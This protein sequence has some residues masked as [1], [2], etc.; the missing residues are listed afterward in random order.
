[1]AGRTGHLCEIDI[2]ECLSVELGCQN[3]GTCADSNDD[4]VIALAE[5]IC[6]CV[7]GWHGDVCTDGP[8]G[9][10]AEIVVNQTALECSQDALHQTFTALFEP[11]AQ[12]SVLNTSNL[13]YVVAFRPHV[14]DESLT[15]VTLRI[16]SSGRVIGSVLA[17]QAL[18]LNATS[19]LV[20]VWEILEG[21]PN[22]CTNCTH[23]HCVGESDG[24]A[25]CECDDGWIGP[26]C[27]VDHDECAQ[28]PCQNSGICSDSTSTMTNSTNSTNL[29]NSNFTGSTR[30]G[31]VA[32]G[33]FHC[34]C[35]LGWGG[36]TCESDVDECASAPCQN[37]GS[38][39]ESTTSAVAVGRFACACTGG[40]E[41]VT[42]AEDVDECLADNCHSAATCA[43]SRNWQL[44]TNDSIAIGQ[45]L[46]I[47]PP[48]YMQTELCDQD[49]DECLSN[50]CQNAGVC[51]ESAVAVCAYFNNLGTPQECPAAW[52]PLLAPAADDFFCLCD[53]GWSGKHCEDEQGLYDPCHPA[54][55]ERLEGTF[56]N[57][58]ENASCTTDYP[59]VYHSYNC[60]CAYGFVGDGDEN[61]TD[62]DECASD[63][64][65]SHTQACLESYTSANISGGYFN[66][67]CED[68]YGGDLC[69]QDIDECASNPCQNTDRSSTRN[70]TCFASYT[71]SECTGAWF[72]DPDRSWADCIQSMWETVGIYR[73]VCAEGFV[74]SNCADDVDECA[75]VPCGA[76]GA[77][78]E[79]SADRYRK[80][81]VC[82]ICSALLCVA[83][84]I[85]AVC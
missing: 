85:A 22:N 35:A 24:I 74:G 43:D 9:A 12:D 31:V 58:T 67:S 47:C 79:S 5:V 68:G 61:C 80:T 50:P 72:R 63:P 15:I 19:Q 84:T 65:S 10:G 40:W 20:R 64:C 7:D 1:M 76:H 17:E 55:P 26:N 69:E 38:C 53:L 11:H 8:F 2:D 66:C 3:N 45:F 42:C 49:I 4:V 23:G 60:S 28:S 21:V 16:K 6:Q 34:D 75:S 14:L 56:H 39:S 77:C 51:F 54:Y 46:C 78:L 33:Q 48:G 41:N 18:N 32:V 62:I 83:H 73:C 82:N 81:T 30:L 57:C 52:Q 71:S 27:E 37:G 44:F 29:T 70:G 59:A 36:E 25:T 13:F